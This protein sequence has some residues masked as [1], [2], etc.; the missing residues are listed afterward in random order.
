[1]ATKARSHDESS[2]SGSGPPLRGSDRAI[3][4][5]ARRALEVAVDLRRWWERVD[6]A[7]AYT[8]RYTE[9][10]VFR[11]PEDTSFGFFEDAE[12]MNG[13]LPIIGNVQ[14]MRYDR[15][16]AGRSAE[17]MR[18]Q[19]KAFVLKYFMRV[20]DFRNPQQVPESEHSELPGF[21]R[22]FDRRPDDDYKTSG[23]GY[24]Q[25]YYRLQKTG[26]EG[27][28]PAQQPAEWGA[29]ELPPADAIID[30]GGLRDT[31][32]WIVVKNPIE[33]FGFVFAPLGA[34]GPQMKLPVKAANH[35]VLSRDTITIDETD[36]GDGVLGR[37]GIGYGFIKDPGRPGVFA[38]GPGQLEP[39]LQLIIWE[40]HD[41]G[42]VYV[43]MTFVSRAP[44]ALLNM[45]LNPLQWGFALTD[46]VAPGASTGWLRP[47]KQV[48]DGLPFSDVV[49]DPVLPSVKLLNLLTGNVAG[50]YFGISERDID[51]ELLYLHFMQHYDA[52]LGSLQTWRQYRDWTKPA[53]LPD[54]VKTGV[55]A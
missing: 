53:A 8:D 11:R 38:Y 28:F 43:R 47:F 2:G 25:L 9:T 46:L 1:M 3:V 27:R 37:Y 48:A 17:A 5:G 40:V 54:W 41:N 44:E 31:Y 20:S 14:R 26:E 24:R 51:K 18:R 32:E 35:L 21:L 39:A 50:K 6:R 42:E 36:C 16:K 13:T 19:I 23:F 30:L 55:S 22:Y 4:A 52:V 12:L 33:D 7:D 10:F 15:T 45:S 29:V 34:N 49:V